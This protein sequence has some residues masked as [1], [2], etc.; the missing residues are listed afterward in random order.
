MFARQAPK[1]RV[2]RHS[3]GRNFV[4]TAHLGLKV[5][6]GGVETCWIECA[7][8]RKSWEEGKCV[9]LDT[10]FEHETSNQSDEDR[11]VLIIDFWHPDLTQSE[12]NALSF[13][14][15]LRYKYDQELIENR[16]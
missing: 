10:S 14:Y 2:A 13:I 6:E 8:V 9:V 12:R 3:D 1:S 5:P 15:D 4:L 11:H 16:R 7:G